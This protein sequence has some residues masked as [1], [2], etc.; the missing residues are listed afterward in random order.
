MRAP[1]LRSTPQVWPV[2]SM[3]C[4]RVFN[5]HEE[6]EIMC[7]LCGKAA[8]SVGHILAGCSAL[9]QSKYLQRHNAVLKIL[10]FEML[11]S[12]DLIDSVSPWYSP[13]EPKPVYENDHAKAFWDV[14]VYADHVEVRA[15][16]IDARIIDNSAKTV[17]LLEMSYPWPDNRT[18]KSY[19]KTEKY[20]PLRLELKRQF[21][22]FKVKQFNI[23]MD[24]LGGYS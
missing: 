11:Y 20:A 23:I 1:G 22:G 2:Y 24:V 14:P 16:R 21:Q 8:E 4:I 18:S 17:I 7:R 5:C 13:T 9:A 19:E 15:N 10:F 12:L 3:A 6:N